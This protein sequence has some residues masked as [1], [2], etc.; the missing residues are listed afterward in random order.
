[1]ELDARRGRL[2]PGGVIGAGAS[3]TSGVVNL[4]GPVNVPCRPYTRARRTE[5]PGLGTTEHFALS[6]QH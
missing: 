6:T 5:D 2:T 1:M 3:T 4:T